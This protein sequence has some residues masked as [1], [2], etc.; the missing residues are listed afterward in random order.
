[1]LR[2]F[3]QN[4]EYAIINNMDIRRYKTWLEVDQKALLYNAATVR[5]FVGDDVALMAAVKAN[6]YGHGLVEVAQ[7]LSGQKIEGLL[8]FA[9]KPWFGVDSI[10]EALLVQRY[11]AHQPIM[12]FGYIPRLRIAEVLKKNFHISI[13]SK[14]SFRVIYTELKKLTSKKGAKKI[15]TH[16]HL[17]IETGTNRLGLSLE[18]LKVFPAH[19]PIEGIYTHFSEVENPISRFYQ[20]Q[21][22]LLR[23]A[24]T[25]LAKKDIIPRFV[26][27]A[28][29][30]A[31][32]QYPE[33]HGNLV[34]LGIG[35]YGLWPSESVKHRM[36]NIVSLQPVLTWKT[37]IA[38][39]KQIKKGE[40]VGYD[41]VW[42]AS[43]ASIIAILPVGYYDGYDRRLSNCGEV[44]IRG[45]RAPVIG[46]VCMNMI[47]VDV[48]KI[49]ARQSVG[50]KNQKS[51]IKIGDE[52]VL[53]G[54]QGNEEISADEIAEKTGTI[55]YEVVSR[56]NPLFPRIVV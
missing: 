27:S 20:K 38:Q 43:H 32:L 26:H 2:F 42:R 40:T 52:V 46:R 15:T 33:T 29:T 34:R 37:R 4:Q 18:D 36:S 21:L 3:V 5:R 9:G 49:L 35:L 7:M 45:K 39:I 50:W 55:H 53:L 47:M 31:L 54:R 1:M 11:S 23:R 13:Y 28:S 48:T 16:F 6:A 22:A 17:K 51:K 14:E 30:A 8:A 25:I 41:R 44:L 12:I 56:I 10:D 24:Q 19:F